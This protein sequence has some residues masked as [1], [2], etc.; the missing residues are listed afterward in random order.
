MVWQVCPAGQSDA[1]GLQSWA[2]G[3]HWALAGQVVK[4]CCC[5]VRPQLKSVQQT[6]PEG[7]SLVPSQV[8]KLPEMLPVPHMGWEPAGLTGD[9]VYPQPATVVEQVTP[10]AHVYTFAIP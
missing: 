4:H 9:D 1:N 6:W 8:M 7:Q 10:A 5:V 2:Q 3:W